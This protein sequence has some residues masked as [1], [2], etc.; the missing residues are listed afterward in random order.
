MNENGWTPGFSDIIGF[1]APMIRL[2]G[3]TIIKLPRPYVDESCL[4]IQQ[5]GIV[6]FHDGLRDLIKEREL[7][8]VSISQQTYWVL[9][10]LDELFKY[11]QYWLNEQSCRGNQTPIEFLDDLHKRHDMTTV[12]FV[13][14]NKTTGSEETKYQVFRYTD[15]MYSHIKHAVDHDFTAIKKARNHY[16]KKAQDW[17]TEG[18]HVY[19]NMIP[20][21]ID[22]MKQKGCD[23]PPLVEEAWF[24]MMLRAFL[25]HRTHSMAE[26]K[27]VPS[28]HWG[29]RLHVYIG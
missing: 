25:W 11:G 20:K 8:R 10:Q 2:P 16:G 27:T 15:L 26:G 7:R 12:Y 14:L 1:A 6:L 5:E 21:I 3:S 17:I 13:S 22:T 24:T 23:N 19:F 9:R 29:S 18:A 28:Q 4:T